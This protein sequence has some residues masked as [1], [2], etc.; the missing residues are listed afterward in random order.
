M[1]G[2]FRL[3]RTRGQHDV[4]SAPIAEGRS[5]IRG[6]PALS[7]SPA[8]VTPQR[9]A[10]RLAR[11]RC[12]IGMMRTQTCPPGDGST[13]L[14]DQL[15]RDAGWTR[16]LA[17]SL[18]G[19]DSAG[20]DA[21]QEA[22]I[23]ARRHPPDGRAPL[24]PWVR[25]VVLNDL[26]NQARARRR[27]AHREADT[28]GGVDSVATAVSPEELLG[29]VEIHRRLV[30]A[31]A[32]LAEP[33]RQT[34]LLRYFE[35][36]SS[37]EI[38][39]R[40]RVPAATVRGRLKTAL[41]EL[42]EA[43]DARSSRRDEWLVELA[44][45]LGS[46]SGSPAPGPSPSPSPAPA[47]P[48]APSAAPVGHAARALL[49]PGAVMVAAA[50]A[51]TAVVWVRAAAPPVGRPADT[52]SDSEQARR[53]Q[54]PSTAAPGVI[55]VSGGPAGG[56]H[57]SS[58]ESIAGPGG[59]GVVRTAARTSSAETQEQKAVP[60]PF[61]R[62]LGDRTI[63]GMVLIESPMVTPDRDRPERRARR[64]AAAD[65]VMRI[66]DAPSTSRAGV[67]AL[68][69]FESRMFLLSGG[70]RPAVRVAEVGQPITF[71]N[72]DRLPHTVRASQGSAKV[73]E[74]RLAP[75]AQKEQALLAPAGELLR[76]TLDDRADGSA[77][78]V[79]TDNPFHT[80]TGPQGWFVLSD[81][82]AGTYTVEAWR[83]DL[84]AVTAQVRTGDLDARLVFRRN[85]GDSAFA[86]RASGGT[87]A[88]ATADAPP[89]G[90]WSHPCQIA[91]AGDG[92]IAKACNQGG[93]AQ[94]QKLMKLI[95]TDAKRNGLSKRCTDCHRE[96][97]RTLL[98]GAAEGLAVLLRRADGERP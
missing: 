10:K 73:F 6:H 36:L 94:A 69:L 56:R 32:R 1:Q 52:D 27:R 64:V 46:A 26:L 15:C 20:E 9:K 40:M 14:Q 38:G 30:E 75:G 66:K 74:E 13:A 42:R 72:L 19:D 16:R 55:G 49:R 62:P 59:D 65:V 57:D 17:R 78:V 89:A 51:L 12:V 21:S 47:G 92:P 60:S 24:G 50:S 3:S 37:E 91:I 88:I 96:D 43:L 23:R 34:V 83:E 54:V 33:H 82:P 7:P 4:Q 8:R 77:V 41:A 90:R 18:L 76:L 86:G 28:A 80:V 93:I 31:V 61:S 48:P 25:A 81:V 45:F 5:G 71:V 70:L 87:L 11:R 68:T 22:W 53:A 63:S 84:G 39:T 85:D 67:T 29:R 97:D 35:E 95:V 2:G 58:V 44:D 98:P 79:M